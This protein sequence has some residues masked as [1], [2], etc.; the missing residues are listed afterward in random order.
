MAALV[1]LAVGASFAGCGSGPVA[2]PTSYSQYNAKDGTFAC[3]YP[4]GWSAD[5]GG[6][7]GPLWA[8]F[9]SGPAEIRVNADVAG[10]LM[11]DIAGSVGL[12]GGQTMPIDLEPVAKVHELG[13]ETAAQ[14]YSGYTEVGNATELKA[15]LGPA[16]RSEFTATTAFGSGQHG[17]RATILAKDKRVVV[18]CA[19]PESDWQTLEPAFARVLE[20]FQRGNAE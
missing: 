9:T 8:T 15:G 20:S 14:K 17:Y 13:K 11:G 19:C 4:D 16:R 5:G 7:N 12:G 2:A 6:K 3:E 1:V 18:F 10:S